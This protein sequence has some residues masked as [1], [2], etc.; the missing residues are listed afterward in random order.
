MEFKNLQRKSELAQIL[1]KDEILPND[2]GK[3][4]AENKQYYSDEKI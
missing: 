2:L 3:T 1:I 4:K